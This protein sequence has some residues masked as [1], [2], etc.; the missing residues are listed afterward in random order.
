M[1]E[2]IKKYK[3]E[4]TIGTSVIASTALTALG[5]RWA[6][7]AGFQQ[8][9]DRLFCRVYKEFPELDLHDFWDKYH[10]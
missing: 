6:Y 4:I 3:T 9:C 10:K 5:M 2:K 1:K 8:G 7:E